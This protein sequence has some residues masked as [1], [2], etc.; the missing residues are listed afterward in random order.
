MRVKKSQGSAIPIVV[1]RSQ[2]RGNR[3][4][5]IASRLGG[6]SACFVNGRKIEGLKE[7]VSYVLTKRR[8]HGRA[9]GLRSVQRPRVPECPMSEM[10]S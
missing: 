7:G 8:I 4:T 9:S 5:E 10:L 3:E 1:F 2:G 6:V